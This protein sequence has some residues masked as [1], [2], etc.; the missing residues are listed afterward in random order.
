MEDLTVKKL[1][2]SLICLATVCFLS[3]NLLAWYPEDIP[4]LDINDVDRQGIHTAGTGLPTSATDGWT[5]GGF[6]TAGGWDDP[7][8]PI[9]PA[10]PSYFAY[11]SPGESNEFFDCMWIFVYTQGA[12]L[13]DPVVSME[14]N[15]LY[16]HTVELKYDDDTNYSASSY[17]P[18][19]GNPED[20]NLWVYYIEPQSATEII[21]FTQ[22]MHEY[23][24]EIYSKIL[25]PEPTTILLLLGSIVGLFIKKF[26]K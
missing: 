19:V 15:A 12:T 1:F 25:I 11:W 9:D 16:T 5:G 14:N 24:M 13:T 21:Y 23:D 4:D 22:N 2:S 8:D 7:L 20:W 26:K 18:T 6:W 17:W 3:T 10:D